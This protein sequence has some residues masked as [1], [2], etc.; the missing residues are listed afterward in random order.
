MEDLIAAADRGKHG[1]LSFPSS[2]VGTSAVMFLE[3]KIQG[4]M[5]WASYTYKGQAA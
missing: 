4:E 1:S 3:L 5:K 2:I